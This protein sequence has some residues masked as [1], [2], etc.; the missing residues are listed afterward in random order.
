VTDALGGAA[1]GPSGPEAVIEAWLAEQGLEHERRGTSWS[2]ALPGERKLQTPVRLDLGAHALAVHA[3]VCRRP[4]ENHERVYRWMLEQNLRT[5]GVAFALDPAGDIYLDGRLP[6]SVVTHEELDRLL[7][8]VLS[9]ADGSF[10]T[11]LELGFADSI[12]K[13]WEWRVSRG[14]STRNLD[15]FRGWLERS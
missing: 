1:D 2:F 10:N 6:R 5:F 11:L 15:A 13:E 8:S 3:F 7:G 12:R 4:D 14:E 9:V